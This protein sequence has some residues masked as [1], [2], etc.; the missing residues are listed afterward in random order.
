MR[1]KSESGRGERPASGGQPAPASPEAAPPSV[2]GASP[3][4]GRAGA[5]SS[6]RGAPGAS[7][8]PALALPK[9][10]GAIR[11]IGE[12]L[13]TNPATGTASL[14]VPL[15]TSPGR[16]DF[17]LGLALAY[18]SGAGNGPFGLGWSLSVPSVSRKTDQG[19][20][21]YG[22]DE[23]DT[24][25]LSGAEDLVPVR[26]AD[27]QPLVLQRGEHRV[28]RYRPRTEGLYAR[29][30]S[31]THLGSGQVHWRVTTRDN[32]LN[33]YGRTAAAQLAD[34]EHA[35]RVFSWLLEETRDDRGN[36]VRYSYK[37]EDGAGIDPGLAS[38][39]NRF[40]PTAGG[41]LS[42]RAT[43]Q[44]YP[45][46]IQYGNRVPLLDREAAL[47][48]SDDAYLFEVVFDYGE[49]E[50]TVPTPVE[51]R[52][53]P[54][55]LD[56]FSAFRATFE[57]RTLRLC[58]R[59][60]MFHR[61][62]ELGAAP[63]LVRSTD[64]T[65]DEGPA[66]T[67]LVAVELAGY[68]RPAGEPGTYVRAALPA[69]Q[70]DY[71]RLQLRDELRTMPADSLD[72]LRSGV[73][74]TGA[75]WVDLDGE[76]ISGVLIPSESS[77][78]YKANLGDGKLA[79]PA[80]LPSL[81]SPAELAG[82]GQQLTDLDGD[83]HLELVSY[84]PPLAGYFAR[85]DE[86]SWAPFQP[87]PA[88]PQL[89]W[90][91]PN[92][93]F[94]DLDGDGFP[95]VLITEDDAFVWYRSRAKDG[96]APAVRLTGAR[97]EREGPKVLFAD[98][99]ESVSLADMSGDGLVDLVRVR[100]GE[101]CYWPNLGHGRF[102]RKITLEVSAALDDQAHFDPRRVRFAD[103]DGSGPSDLLYL[104]RDGVRLYFNQAGNAL[105]APV[106]IR[107]LPPIDPLSG[108]AVADLLGRG[109]ACLVWS[110]PLPGQRALAYIELMGGSKPHL[111]TAMRNQLGAE[112]RLSYESSTAFYLADKAAGKPWL[113]RLAFP[114]HVVS[115]IERVDRVTGA[116]QVT[117][118]AYHHGYFD[119]YERE[120]HGFARVEQWDAESFGAAPSG[121]DETRATEAAAFAVP[122]VRT[123]T[124]YH[125]G[126]WLERERLERELAK[127]YYAA[128][129]QAP[130]APEAPLPGGLTVRE[131]RAAARA[132]R[133]QILRQE[134]YAEDGV[135]ASAHPYSVS[136]RS[137][138]VR[139]L[140]RGFAEDPAVFA[141][142]PL[143][144]LELHYERDPADPRLVHQL[145]LEVDEFGN[146][147]KA[148]SIAY[149]RRAPREPEQARLWATFTESTFGNR[150]EEDD[151]YRVGVPVETTTSEL[152]GVRV[153]AVG[154]PEA[155]EVLALAVGASER[156][157]EVELDPSAPGGQRRVIERVRHWYYKDDLSG[158]L[159]LGVIEPRALPYDQEKLALTPG[160]LAQVFGDRL[161]DTVLITE[162]GYVRDEHGF[163]LP[164][165]R[166]ELDP[167]RFFLP[168]AAIDPFGHRHQLRYD[169]Y[170]LLPLDLEDPL[171]NRV[172][173]GERDAAGAIL[174][175]GNDYRVLAPALLTDPNRNR[176]A[177]AFDALGQVTALAVMGKAGQAQGDSLDG[178]ALDLPLAAVQAFAADPHGQAAALLGSATTRIVHDY[179]RYART[180]QP[181]FTAQVA[182]ET[183][184]AE[185]AGGAQ[186]KLQISI[187]YSDGTGHEV[188]TKAQAESG[189]AALR[190][191]PVP[192]PGGDL[193]P[194]ALV[195]DQQGQVVTGP[196]ARRWV[197]S[198]RVVLNN[199]GKPVKQYEP[200]FSATPLYEP[201]G[202]VTD[203][204]VSPVLFYDPVE[205]VVATLHPNQTYEKVVF[206]AW[207]E[208]HYDVNDTV[209]A[210]GAQTGD[211]RTDPD[212]AGYVAGY[213]ATQPASWKTWYAQRIDGQLGAAERDAAQ[214][215]AV[216]GDTP[217]VKQV[218]AL[219][220]PFV[221]LAHNRF[222][223]GGVAIEEA[224]AT[225]VALDLEGNQRQ[226]K[227]ALG[228]AVMRY[229]QGLLSQPLHQASMEAGE[230][231]MVGDVAGQPL[232]TWDSRGF[233]RRMTYD[234]LRRPTGLYVRADA[235]ER[236]AE[237]TVYGEAQGDATNHRTRAYQVFDGAGVVTSSAY[238][239]KGNLISGHRRFVAGY[240]QAVDWQQAP[241]LESET[242]STSMRYDALAR[243]VERTTPDGSVQRP[244]YNEANLLEQ[245]QVRLRGAAAETAVVA[246]L[247]YDAKGQRVRVAYGNGAVTTYEYDPQTF[248]LVR[249][250]TTRPANPDGTASLLFVSASVVQDLRYTYDPAGNLTRIEDAALR[251]VFHDNQQVDPLCR[252]SYDAVYRLIEAQGREH[253]AQ[254]ALALAPVDGNY[255]DLPFAGHRVAA[256]DGQALRRYVQQYE[257]D[258]V[259][260]FEVL[261]HVAGGTGWT[262]QYEYSEPS[263][264]EPGKVSNRL[265]RTVIG[266][267][268][269]EYQHDAHGSMTRMP[270][271]AAMDWDFK[272]QLTRVSLGGGGTAYYVYDA[273]GQRVRKVLESSSG[274]LQKERR[275]LGSFEV[276]REVGA[277]AATTLERESLHVMDDQ[278]RVALVETLTVS[279]GGPLPAP[280]PLLRL[281]LGNHLG[282]S[283]VELDDAGALIAYEEYHPYGT[284]SYQASRSAAE[285]SLKR[286]RYTGKERD[287]ETGFSYHGARYYALW[288]GRWTTVDPLGLKA[289]VN[290]Y[291]Y[292][293]GRPV[294]FHDPDG[295]RQVEGAASA[296]P[297]LRRSYVSEVPPSSL[298]KKK[299]TSGADTLE[300]VGGGARGVDG[301]RIVPQR[302]RLEP[303][304]GA[305]V[306]GIRDTQAGAVRGTPPKPV[307]KPVIRVDLPHSGAP[308]NHI[309]IESLGKS[310]PHFRVSPRTVKLLGGAA[311]TIEGVGR[312]A[313][314]VAI[315]VDVVRIVSAVREDGGVGRSTARTVAS[316]AGGWAGA[317][318][319]AWVGAKGGALLGGAIGSVV[320]GLGTAAG[321]AVGGF[322]GGLIGGVAGSI[323]GA[324]FVES[325]F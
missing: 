218:D 6:E 14:S 167:A 188:Q 54:V 112:T 2:P 104:H 251:T 217:T 116:S 286:Y 290:R 110:S 197:G 91:D 39:A 278:Q 247:D 68:R 127:E 193:A 294:T 60:L 15:A 207:R 292:V 131:E 313:R 148:A 316:V 114:V 323:Y 84:A 12:K 146:T 61:F 322:V 244:V 169:A 213:F 82:G 80:L 141:V 268:V 208:A 135:A 270:H 319:G 27:G 178:V 259:G 299:D 163:W 70:L 74:G 49:H 109:T 99:S 191:A 222:V 273:A 31:W 257:Y 206:D 249:L 184:V 182:R 23:P 160:L 181:P 69:L 73:E 30:E 216:H 196:V 315:G 20:P 180:G 33:V 312:V 161:D 83:G 125:T 56:P 120:F 95:D 232:R 248:R 132:L 19:L 277:G 245:V 21:R 156:P 106:P 66:F 194:G 162:G 174:T 152:V 134:I 123:V 256:G 144:T 220:R 50:L 260:N 75:Q 226:V 238:D 285:A 81:P 102:G 291:E 64:F 62:A 85:T 18:D 65:Y 100:N 239:F 77:W 228:R 147:T 51:A 302:Y 108:V 192:L 45:K 4:A 89:D 78:W 289:G 86:G 237:R 296:H 202:E 272:D 38:E 317:V 320:P 187:S 170:A 314:P 325:K 307:G 90:N 175:N 151:W 297:P 227:D 37:A 267:S 195:R 234:A 55:R 311:R 324:D 58:R 221:T 103:L 87:L 5:A 274:V 46:R 97:D 126:A 29:I 250:R 7:L 122:P 306:T 118:F 52:P 176:S 143:H 224:Y 88:L 57:V 258:A 281:Q 93:R 282:S 261:R 139:V 59:V 63:C 40:A 288:V 159:A 318:G 53:W 230:R 201:E 8:L 154:V 136:E 3:G 287:E 121:L 150:S 271:L 200:F 115:R 255:R 276:Y 47:P 254:T 210:V 236:L 111:L 203:T 305:T 138:R 48:T 177:A 225:R 140:Q 241:A 265:S 190:A 303:K 76:G 25:V 252:Y 94:L 113:T 1:E 310:D 155:A 240:R 22:A 269:E 214:K 231:W 166:L 215:A 35:E 129:T 209:T 304:R 279:A 284:T 293:V 275:Y 128:D 137:H 253:V 264:L 246:G 107:S 71:A 219:G 308:Y 186:S 26:S 205:R 321:A 34:P 42:Y 44:R 242:Y 204:G 96:F 300:V 263:L 79:P 199:K 28:A 24:F 298:P 124:W 295:K 158:R 165:G 10:G 145:V 283:S 280:A 117:R 43:A 233:V 301:D 183:H 133:G 235:V 266:Q 142:D 212:V 130:R 101:I 11:G 168:I 16:S 172:T 198:G 223:R 189:S 153:P 185:L 211:P 119:G 171:G 309:N 157:Y 173:L 149:P 9:G 179:G 32:V 17:E 243:P 72:G 67:Y 92:L 13:S 98:G 105:S 164:A 41:G 36:V 262:R 229:R